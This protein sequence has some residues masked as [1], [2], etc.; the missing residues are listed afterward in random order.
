MPFGDDEVLTLA[1]W[2]C[3]IEQH[4]SA[5]TRLPT[6]MDIEWARTASGELFVVQAG[7]RTVRITQSVGRAAQLGIRSVDAELDQQGRRCARVEQVAGPE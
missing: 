7:R 2:A 1:R 5:S 3:R 4:Y 6:P